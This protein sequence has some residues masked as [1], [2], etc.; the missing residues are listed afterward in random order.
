MWVGGNKPHSPLTQTLDL[1]LTLIGQGSDATL[2]AWFETGYICT[3]AGVYGGIWEYMGVYGGTCTNYKGGVY[4]YGSEGMWVHGYMC[5]CTFQRTLRNVDE[6]R[7][8]ITN[9]TGLI[10]K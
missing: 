6:K 9:I 5:G 4:M 2:R 8:R 7:F 10:F 1:T 3:A